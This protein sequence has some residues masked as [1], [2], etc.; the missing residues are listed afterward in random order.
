MG[1]GGGDG[2]QI[3]RKAVTDVI[4]IRNEIGVKGVG[5]GK[6]K[7]R[8]AVT[9]AERETETGAAIETEKEAAAGRDALRSGGGV[10]AMRGTHIMVERKDAGERRK[11]EEGTDT[12][13]IA[14]VLKMITIA[15]TETETGVEWT[16]MGRGEGAGKGR[17]PNR[18]GRE[19]Q[20]GT[21]ETQLKRNQEIHPFLEAA[22]APDKKRS[23]ESQVQV[24]LVVTPLPHLILLLIIQE[25]T[26][27][28]KKIVLR[29][30]K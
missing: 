29:R 10:E 24:I 21:I 7:E 8:E 1:T 15:E 17:T 3:E 28:Q 11:V 26:V 9:E 13:E 12:A 22:V 23:K 30:V 6:E 18:E 19:S 27:L 25:L 16:I 14:L 2:V 20:K 4:E 5:A